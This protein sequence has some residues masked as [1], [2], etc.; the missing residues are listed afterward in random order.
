MFSAMQKKIR[1]M[2]IATRLA[3]SFLLI[4]VLLLAVALQTNITMR[5]ADVRHQ[6]NIYYILGRREIV[7]R[8]Q[9][10]FNDFRFRLRSS[11]MSITWRQE[12]G[13]HERRN[14]ARLLGEHHATLLSLAD[15]HIRLA[16]Y[17][18]II[19]NERRALVIHYMGEA[20]D[21]F[22]RIYY[23]FFNHFFRSD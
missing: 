14:D 2:K 11:Y 5:Q 3:L 19:S 13:R 22:C 16:T 20:R 7:F 15:E 4:I 1:R 9:G 10:E 8:I 18:P 6:D 12:A 21:Y 17:D 23:Q